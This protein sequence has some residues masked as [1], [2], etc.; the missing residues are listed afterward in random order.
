[1]VTVAHIAAMASGVVKADGP[2]LILMESNGELQKRAGKCQ[3][4]TD[5]HPKISK[6]YV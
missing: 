5:H 3:V 6:T 1:M 4:H 2:Q